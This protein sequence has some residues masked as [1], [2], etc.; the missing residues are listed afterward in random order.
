MELFL[1]SIGGERVLG[2][3]NQVT[4]SILT[5]ELEKLG[6]RIENDLQ[7]LL[8]ELSGNLED[9]SSGTHIKIPLDAGY[10]TC[11]MSQEDFKI[12]TWMTDLLMMTK[13]TT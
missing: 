5:E 4:M 8:T 1:S 11:Y 7:S 6:N 9:I 3:Q 12:S 10:V 2:E 13:N